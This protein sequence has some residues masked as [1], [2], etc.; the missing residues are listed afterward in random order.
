MPTIAN[1]PGA[2]LPVTFASGQTRT[3]NLIILLAQTQDAEM[4]ARFGIHLP[5]VRGS[6]R[7]T[8]RALRDA[9][10]LDYFFDAPVRTWEDAALVM[11][12]FYGLCR[13]HVSQAA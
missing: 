12:H 13:E 1:M 9:Y 10:E 4:M 11:R 7:P 3:V 8:I 6:L 5:G 2:D